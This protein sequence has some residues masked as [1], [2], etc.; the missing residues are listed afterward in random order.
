ME[1]KQNTTQKSVHNII[2]E[3][4]DGYVYDE[5]QN[6]QTNQFAGNDNSIRTPQQL[7]YLNNQ[8]AWVKLASS[9]SIDEEIGKARIRSLWKDI[10]QKQVDPFL[11]SQLAESAILFNSLSSNKVDRGT[12]AS[13]GE[14]AGYTQRSGVNN[15]KSI[16]N[17]NFA[18]G[19]GGTSFGLTPPPGIDSFKINCLSRGSIREATV[20]IKAFNKFQ[21]E[22]IELLYLRLGYIMALEWGNNFYLKG[23]DVKPLRNTLIENEWFNGSNK[24][25]ASALY[26]IID[27]VGEYRQQYHGNYDGFIGKVVNF[28]WDFTPE[29]IYNITL[30]LVTVGDVIESLNINIPTEKRKSVSSTTNVKESE[31]STPKINNHAKDILS[32]WVLNNIYQFTQKNQIQQD[33]DP[34]YFKLVPNETNKKASPQYYI[35]LG[36][37]LEILEELCVPYIVA[38]KV[39]GP[40]LID[41]NT[42]TETNII[43]YHPSQ[44]PLDPRVC[45]FK[46]ENQDVNMGGILNP[47]ELQNLPD[48]VISDPKS[49]IT[50]GILMNLCLN[51]NFIFECL[52]S[53]NPI[54]LFNLLKKICN[55]INKSLGDVNKLEPVLKDERKVF[56]QDQIPI[57]GLIEKI[58]K[59][60]NDIIPLEIYGYNPN[61]KSSNFVKNFS[62]TTNI[63]P[64]LSSMIT[65]GAAAT[66][67]NAKGMDSTGYAKWAIGLKDRFQ[68]GLDYKNNLE[69]KSEE[70]ESEEEKNQ[71][72]TKNWVKN[73]ST[74]RKVV[75]SIGNFLHQMFSSRNL[76][77]AEIDSESL[78]SDGTAPTGYYLLPDYLKAAKKN[79]KQQTNIESR[80]KRIK[81]SY[82]VHLAECFGSTNALIGDN[83]TYTVIKENSQYLNFD[84]SFIE[85]GLPKYKEY[86][87]L[88]NNKIFL[89]S[90]KEAQEKNTYKNIYSSGQVGFIPVSLNLTLQGISGIKIYNKLSVDQRFLPP[91]YPDSLH[92]VITKVNHKIVNNEWETELETI[93]IPVTENKFKIQ[94]NGLAT[95]S[96]ALYD[97]APLP[98]EERLPIPSTGRFLIQEERNAVRGRNPINYVPKGEIIGVEKVLQDI[99]P[100]AKNAFRRFLNGLNEKYPGYKM[101]L[102]AIGRSFEKSAELEKQNPENSP[103]GFS[104]HN[105]Y[106]AMDFNIIDPNGKNYKKSGYKMDWINSG[107][108]DLA[109][110][111][112]LSWGGEFSNY[113]DDIHFYYDFDIKIAYENAGKIASKENIDITKVDGYK[114]PL[115]PSL[116]PQTEVETRN[117][118]FSLN[119]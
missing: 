22:L 12:D 1:G 37:F 85:Q 63:T 31:D 55:G 99:N 64:N 43:S 39:T 38:D 94:D 98:K 53:N 88:L 82:I 18:Y 113:E 2:G 73:I 52:K 102:S 86:L 106:A 51:T 23:N 24:N 42:V 100:D 60:N 26:E 91:N 57:S 93:S 97:N 104:K 48:Y 30:N 36:K 84:S 7:Q 27:L 103:P 115:G 50:G 109:K 41:I 15:S 105:Y 110:D 25:K 3:P 72:Y 87:R 20:E 34:D 79:E 75:K 35:R 80:N 14:F 58:S 76:T 10:P 59:D 6:R 66:G 95:Y 13:S 46:F 49:G 71:R 90:V 54:T 81:N 108:V 28:K 29:G 77:R 40:P 62:F 5:I 70:P 114:V 11:G 68:P 33:G 4:F 83:E 9:V 112:G 118:E 19:L 32:G 45:I 116:G 119:S 101:I 67:G 117:N 61:T 65:I 56:I 69:E 92:F 111:S 78:I 89:Q 96:L 44:A 8:N 21:F 47:K 17:T 107:I 74:S 16:W